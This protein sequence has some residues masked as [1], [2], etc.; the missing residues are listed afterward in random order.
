MENVKEVTLEELAGL[1]E[2]Q[3]K[4]FIIHVELGK[5]DNDGKG[6]LS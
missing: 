2:S 3:E 1:I 6:G 5:G 4:K